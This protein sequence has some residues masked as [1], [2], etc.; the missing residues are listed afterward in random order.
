MRRAST[1][2]F[3]SLTDDE[4]LTYVDLTERIAAAARVDTG[5]HLR[6]ATA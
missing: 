4:L 5:E 3:M 6:R 2:V 1:E